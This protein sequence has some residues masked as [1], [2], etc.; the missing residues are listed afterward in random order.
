MLRIFIKAIIS[1]VTSFKYT[2]TIQLMT[3]LCKEIADA[4][5]FQ[6]PVCCGSETTH[7]LINAPLMTALFPICSRPEGGLFLTVL[8]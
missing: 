7:F 5:L 2:T 4:W 1:S 3:M 8:G 6:F